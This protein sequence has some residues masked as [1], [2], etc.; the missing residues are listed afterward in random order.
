LTKKNPVGERRKMLEGRHCSP[1]ERWKTEKITGETLEP[2]REPL[3][4]AMRK[5]SE[6]K[7]RKGG[8][9]ANKKK[10]I[11]CGKRKKKKVISLKKPTL[12]RKLSWLS[13]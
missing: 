1:P 11:H 8:A 3:S 9:E 4:H 2:E 7:E 6:E 10:R 13:Q 12:E 5:C